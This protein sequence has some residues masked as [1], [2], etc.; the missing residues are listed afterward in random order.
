MPKRKRS[1]VAVVALALAAALPATAS[2]AALQVKNDRGVAQY[3]FWKVNEEQH[4]H[5]TDGFG[6]AEIEV[7]PGDVVRVTRTIGGPPD[8]P[9][10]EGYGGLA[11]TVPD[12]AP[13]EVTITLPHTGPIYEPQ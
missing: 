11:Y 3:S 12:P 10:P 2:A 8:Y 5:P 9:P 4:W 7:V 13:A 1:A 6:A